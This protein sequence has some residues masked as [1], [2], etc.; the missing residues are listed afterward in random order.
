MQEVS[1]LYPALNTSYENIKLGIE[2]QKNKIASE[3]KDHAQNLKNYTTYHE[4]T[5]LSHWYHPLVAHQCF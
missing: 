5:L 3:L 1:S 4:T 2:I